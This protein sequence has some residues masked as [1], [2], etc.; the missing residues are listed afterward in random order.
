MN[1]LLWLILVRHPGGSWDWVQIPPEEMRENQVGFDHR[2]A[3]AGVYVI[4]REYFK[5]PAGKYM[6]LPIIHM[7]IEF[8]TITDMEAFNELQEALDYCSFFG[9]MHTL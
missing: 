9:G 1:G 7:P 8:C 5:T 6:V 2:G 3:P 4:E